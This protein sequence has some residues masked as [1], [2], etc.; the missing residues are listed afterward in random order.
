MSRTYMNLWL[1]QSKRLGSDK[2]HVFKRSHFNA[3]A[4][5]FVDTGDPQSQPANHCKFALTSSVFL[6]LRR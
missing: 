3:L 5:S 2:V 4:D 1:F 6:L